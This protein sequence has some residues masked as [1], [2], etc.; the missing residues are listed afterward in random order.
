MKKYYIGAR[1]IGT[2]IGRGYDAD[3]MHD[4]LSE[5]I[6][7]AREKISEGSVDTCVIV[8]IVRI[9]KRS[10]PPIEVIEIE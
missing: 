10:K 5:A 4:N 7:E 2:A 1:H 8:K 9:V 3:C 6:T